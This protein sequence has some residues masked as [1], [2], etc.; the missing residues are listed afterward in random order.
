VSLGSWG[1]L[2]FEVSGE[3][4]LTWQEFVRKGEGRWAQHDVFAG[5]P[6]PEFIGP[7]LDELSMTVLLTASQRG[8]VFL[9]ERSGFQAASRGLVPLDEI[10]YLR[11]QRDLGAVHRLVVGGELVFECTL[12]ALV[13]RHKRWDARAVLLSAVVELT[14]KEYV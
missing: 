8:V 4:V 7:G 3:R 11:E 12:G 6:R 10:K 14:F 1:D 2:V 9:D 5:K 13:E